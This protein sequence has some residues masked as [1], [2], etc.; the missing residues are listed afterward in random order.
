MMGKARE[1][2]KKKKIG[3][4]ERREEDEM[5]GSQACCYGTLKN[6][7]QEKEKSEACYLKLGDFV[8]GTAG[9]EAQD[10]ATW[11]SNYSDREPESRLE[12]NIG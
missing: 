7:N 5:T 8:I 3:E 4:M 11:P 9:S 10:L 6:I 2:K 1:I 12:E